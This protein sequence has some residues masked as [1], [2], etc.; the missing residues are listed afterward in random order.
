MHPRTHRGRSLTLALISLPL[1][2]VHG[3]AQEPL[4]SNAVAVES[5]AE[6]ELRQRAE[7]ALAKGDVAAAE[8][9]FRK[10]A[11]TAPE[12][13]RARLGLGRCQAARG[14]FA[15]AVSTLVEAS[16]R[17]PADYEVLLALAA[18]LQGQA[19]GEYAN[20]DGLAGEMALIDARRMFEEAAARRPD[21]A[22]P[23]LGAAR[24]ERERGNEAEALRL[25][26]RAVA[27]EPKHVDSLIELGSLRFSAY[28]ALL[29]E[30]NVEAAQAARKACT[31]A[32]RAALALDP[33]NGFAMNGLGW[34][35][36]QVGEVAEAA[37]WFKKSL[38]AD[39][40]LDDSYRNLFELESTDR[41]AKKRLVDA[42]DAVVAAAEKVR[43]P[44]RMRAGAAAAHYWRGSAHA[45]LRDLP[46]LRQDFSAAARLDASYRPGCVLAEATALYK[47]NSYDDA[48]KLL[49]ALSQDDLPG[50]LNA[51]ALDRDPRAAALMVTALADQRFKA[52]DLVPA[53]ELFR[54]AAETFVTSADTW[55]NYALLCR[56]T[57]QYEES[58]GAYQRALELDPNNPALLNDTALLLQYHLHRDMDY[59][60]DLYRRAIEEAKRVLGDEQSD[61]YAKDAATTALRDASNNL[62]LLESGK[63]QNG[64]EG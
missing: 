57:A 13:A 52:D 51:I 42:L 60:M 20:G 4:A 18:A 34:I 6:A 2:T 19:R 10:R 8:A 41:E 32:Y 17:L 53:R 38:V 48:T 37:D 59:A 21:A 9:Y 25:A 28:I 23:W 54:I 12:D 45:L 11:E 5:A 56:D 64:E 43:D 33:K 7:S 55:N 22:E 24:V 44:A 40:T 50:L 47:D 26:E 35:A 3:G 58:Y 63:Q 31:D 29:P 36:K 62:R 1:A 61:S 27:L 16:R 30:G 39:T 15:D 49:L 46:K 14:E